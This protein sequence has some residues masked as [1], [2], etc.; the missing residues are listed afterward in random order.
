MAEPHSIAAGVLVGAGI[1]LAGTVMGAQVDALIIGL[2]A[3]ILI[4]FWLPDIDGKLKAGSAIAF[5]SLLAGY[6]SPAFAGWLAENF[7]ALGGIGSLRL[8]IALAI[9]AAGPTLVPLLI[10][11]AKRKVE[12]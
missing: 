9:G 8:P 4:S 10:G 3:A 2:V 7:S 6:W 1:G 12:E 11:R 5:S